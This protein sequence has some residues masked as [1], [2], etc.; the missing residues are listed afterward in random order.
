MLRMAP[1]SQ[2]SVAY[3][4]STAVRGHEYGGGL[5]DYYSERDTRAPKVMVIGDRDFAEET[6]GVTHGGDISQDEVTNWFA[7]G[8]P[9]A[10]PGVGKVRQGRPG[11]DTL[12]AVPKSASILAALAPPEV[13]SI[14]IK[15]V[16]AAVEDALTYQHKHAGYTRVTNAMDPTKKDLQRL[17]ALP[18]V[19][20]LHHTARPTADGTCDPHL[21]VHALL[22]GKV[23]RVDGRMVTVDSESMYHEA[24]AAG[25]I[26]Q[27]AL[28]DRLSA[29][30]GI[31]WDEVDSH[32]GMAEIKGFSRDMLK[33][34]SRRTSEIMEW[35]NANPAEYARKIFDQE[36][37]EGEAEQK[38]FRKGEREHL[39]VAQKATRHKKLESIHYDELREKW[40]NDP[41]AEGFEAREFLGQVAAAAA[42]EGAGIAPQAA[43]VFA[44]LGTAKNSWTRADVVEAV[45][46]LWGPGRGLE[47]S[48]LDQIE[49]LVDE[50]MDATCFQI[51][52]DRAAWHREGH[53]RFTDAATLTREA[54][55]LEMAGVKSREFEISVRQAWFEEK[56]LRPGAAKA[57]T[58]VAMSR[59]FIN[60]LEAPAGTGKT[61]S[62]KALRDRAEAQGKRVV[63]LSSARKALNEARAKEAASELYTIAST[64]RRIEEN[65][66][67]W[68][69]KTVIVIDEAAMTGDRDLHEVFKAA[70]HAHAKVIMVG[71]SRQLQP[72]KAAGGLFRDLS[73]NLPWT[74]TFD[75]VWRQK[76]VEEK[77]MTLLMREAQTESE[78]RKVAFWYRNNGRLHAGDEVSMA[79]AVV[80]RYFD[81]VA[82]GR[83]VMVIADK[84]ST[85]DALNVRIQRINTMALEK[86]MQ[87]SFPTVPIAHDQHARFG[88]I[89][90]TRDNDYNIELRPDPKIRN[91]EGGEIVTNADRWQVQS[92]GED[93]SIEAVRLGDRARAT[94]PAKYVRES[95]VLGYAGTVHASQGANA[96]IGLEIVDPDTAHRTMAY[97]GASR[98]SIEN[99][100]FM[101]QKFAGENE[102]HIEHS[103][104]EP[105]RRVLSDDEAQDLFM[106]ILERDDRERA[107]LAVA[108]EALKSLALDQSSDNYTAH[109]E[110]F[111]GIDP[112][113]AQL[114]HTRAARRTEWATEHAADVA[115]RER[116][117]RSAERV[118]DQA[119]E[120]MAELA[121]DRAKDRDLGR[122]IS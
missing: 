122:D 63:L 120:R 86:E 44:L 22:P 84:W 90:M 81:G 3:Y 54:E 20:Y 17:P 26:F 116:W 57:M 48:G 18:Y 52:E 79:D 38:G 59:R 119:A 56:G 15:D 51:V 4:E 10:G 2:W 49:A 72:V 94:M 77:A 53:L 41:R 100:V 50:V 28:R 76:N 67:D 58:E 16:L 112:Y 29:S 61:T 69:S 6:M 43:D 110:S 118:Q 1:M 85:A 40:Q 68:D 30:L 7:H 75:Y 14:V 109:A 62:L 12:I 92:V 64:R 13:S 37:A 103:D 115:E 83:D 65:R 108:E 46:G 70:A 82:E 25:M 32:T 88:D 89:I 39:D 33:D 98:G 97:V 21:H 36:L 95:V 105:E 55:V 35:A 80:R 114:V 45:V 78:I 87:Q 117:E 102:H 104:M 8:E 71:D 96:E 23:A 60:V 111:N 99:H 19:T 24:K 47:V 42:K 5:S 27:K 91:I 73:E 113:V 11:W 101:A 9:P 66:I 74:Q 93:G 121:E 107:V 34:F 106:K 31:E